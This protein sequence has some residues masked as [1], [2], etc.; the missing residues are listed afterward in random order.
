MLIRLLTDRAPIRQ[1]LAPI[2]IFAMISCSV[3]EVSAQKQVEVAPIP[4]NGQDSQLNQI[5]QLHYRGGIE[6]AASGKWFGGFSG[7]RW[8]NGALHAVSDAGYWFSFVPEEPEGTLTGIKSVAHGRLLDSDGEKLKGKKNRDAESLAIASNGDWLI[9][10]ERDHRI[11]RYSSFSDAA[12]PSVYDLRDIFGKISSNQGI[13]AMGA[14]KGGIFGCV[15]RQ[16]DR[17][18]NCAVVDGE[19]VER[20]SIVTPPPLDKMDGEIADLVIGPDSAAFILFRSYSPA[21]GNGAAIVRRDPG[22]SL[23]TLAVLR[24]PFSLDNMEGLA[25][26]TVD[27]KTYLYVMSDDNFSDTQRTILMKFEVIAGAR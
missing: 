13:E 8:R 2:C 6:L 10:F 16:L 20:I 24:P 5:G 1:L 3:N 25:L 19:G 18:P 7:L 26:R 15:Q 4:L 22:G 27:A 21:N 17:G 23:E 11:A 12:Q 9:G 14:L